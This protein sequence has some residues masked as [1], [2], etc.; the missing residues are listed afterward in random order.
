MDFK[1]F[2]I[3][4][5]RFYF[6][7]LSAEVMRGREEEEDRHPSSH[8]LVVDCHFRGHTMATLVYGLYNADC[9]WKRERLDEDVKGE[10]AFKKLAIT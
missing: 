6:T 8:P 10:V 3:F 7:I 5:I 2:Y 1:F 4:K 9:R